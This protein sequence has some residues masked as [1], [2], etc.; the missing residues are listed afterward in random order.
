MK[1]FNLSK[2]LLWIVI[3]IFSVIVLALGYLLPSVLVPVYENNI[4]NILKQPLDLMNDSDFNNYEFDS[5]IAYLYVTND[6]N[7]IQS[8][9][10]FKVIK[11]S[12]KQILSKIDSTHGKFSYLGK[13]Y[14]YT[15]ETDN[16]VTKIAITN[17][18]YIIKIKEEIIN[19]IFPVLIFTL[20]III[21][22][23]LL[24]S[25]LL[26]KRVEHL[27]EKVD[28]LDN[29]N[30]KNKFNYCFNDELYSLSNSIDSMKETLKRQEEYKNQMYQN[31]SHDFKT[32]ITVIKSYIEG[33]EDGIETKEEG[34]KV[35]KE[36]I[37]KL[38]LKVH[39]LLYLNKLNYIKDLDN[40]K[41]ETTDVSRVII[42][43]VEKFKLQTPN[44][45]WDVNLQD[46]KCIYRGTFDMWEAIIDNLLN[47][48]VRY[49]DKSIKITIKNNKIILYNDGPNID[50]N[51]LNDIFTPYKKGVKGQF[52]LGLSIVKK[53]IMLLGYE[54]SVHN[55]KKGISFI[56]K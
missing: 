20:L 50:P 6:G 48:F 13:T 2:Q 32:P 31:I 29:D 19:T 47:N 12:S 55:E 23:V 17:D 49:A 5:D 46:K 15:S 54:I 11:I 34:L 30:Y 38:E 16:Y 21:G 51:I 52:G 8:T 53:T 40:I 27:K 37:N 14:Y 28:N 44:V 3:V 7:I 43:S 36:Q 35:I 1:D 33:I 39:S 45:K 22:L 24:W 26:I 41:K 56:I 9:N 42:E 10:L 25:Q 18:N 4:Y